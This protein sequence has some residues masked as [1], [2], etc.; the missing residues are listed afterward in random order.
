MGMPPPTA[1][2]N[3]S[4]TPFFSAS[5]GERRAVMRQHRLVGGDD[6]FLRRERGLDQR[7]RDPVLAADQLDDHVDIVAR[8]QRQ[9]ILLERDAGKIEAAVACLVRADTA[10]STMRRV[11]RAASVRR[12]ARSAP[13]ATPAPTVPSPASPRARVWS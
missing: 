4:A 7:P 8:G 3:F 13:A 5:V 2:S 1:A 12:C 11:A 9:R 10:P 6:M